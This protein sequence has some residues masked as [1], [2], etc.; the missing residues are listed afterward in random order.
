MLWLHSIDCYPLSGNRACDQK[1]AGFNPV[2]DYPVFC[3]VQLRYT[4]DYNAPCA[5]AFAGS[6]RCRV[7]VSRK[8]E[9]FSAVLLFMPK[10]LKKGDSGCLVM[11]LEPTAFGGEP[12]PYLIYLG[13]ANVKLAG[14]VGFGVLVE[15][16]RRRHLKYRRKLEA[17]PQTDTH[18][19]R[20]TSVVSAGV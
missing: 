17:L 11:D 20:A 7:S 3:P 14:D 13:R 10:R 1:S 15:Q 2:R 12:V 19:G 6:M 9:P 18:P 8:A 5:R 4:F 16:A